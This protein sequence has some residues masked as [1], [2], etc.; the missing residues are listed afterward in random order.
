MRYRNP[1]RRPTG[2]LCIHQRCTCLPRL[3]RRLIPAPM[4]FV[5]D[6]P[7]LSVLKM[8][9]AQVLRYQP[10]GIATIMYRSNNPVEVPFSLPPALRIF[11]FEGPLQQ[12]VSRNKRCTPTEADNFHDRPPPNGGWFGEANLQVYRNGKKPGVTSIWEFKRLGLLSPVSPT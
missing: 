10:T 6:T 7:L 5:P 1:T 9:R 3:P 4:L 12:E 8:V 2:P 11:V